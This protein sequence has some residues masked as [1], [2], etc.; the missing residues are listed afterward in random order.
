M[1]YIGRSWRQ[2]TWKSEI[3]AFMQTEQVQKL[4]LRNSQK[5]SWPARHEPGN[6]GTR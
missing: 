1:P 2:S 3:R 5:A 4:C 6:G